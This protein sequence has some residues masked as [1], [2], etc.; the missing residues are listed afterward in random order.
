MQQMQMLADCLLLFEYRFFFFKYQHRKA[1]RVKVAQRS[2]NDLII[3]Y[4][5]PGSFIRYHHYVSLPSS[6]SLLHHIGLFASPLS[7]F[8]S[9]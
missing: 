2:T 5:Q 1:Y 3:K 7:H 8:V 9:S 4:L 6:I